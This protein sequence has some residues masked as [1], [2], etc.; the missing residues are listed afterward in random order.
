MPFQADPNT[1][2]FEAETKV[3]NIS[4]ILICRNSS[5]NSIPTQFIS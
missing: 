1:Y 2:H 4:S 5:S 3:D